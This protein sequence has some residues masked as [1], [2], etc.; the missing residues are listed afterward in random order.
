MTLGLLWGIW[1]AINATVF[2][3]Y[4]VD[5]HCGRLDKYTQVKA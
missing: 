4:G 3:L 2:A 5:K 1:A